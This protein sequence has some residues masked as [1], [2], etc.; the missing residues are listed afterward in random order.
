MGLPTKAQVSFLRGLL[1]GDDYNTAARKLAQWRATT[2]V[3]H[4]RGWIFHHVTREYIVTKAG[5]A[6]LALYEAKHPSV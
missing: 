2:S 5:L 6:S 1:R 4:D 3:L